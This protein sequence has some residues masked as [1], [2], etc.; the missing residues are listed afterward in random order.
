MVDLVVEALPDRAILIGHSMGGLIALLAAARRPRALAHL[1]L[2]E[3]AVFPSRWMAALAAR[4]YLAT[5][6]RGDRTRF[7]NSN[8]AT[9]RVHHL[10]RYPRAAIDLYLE[11]R[12]TADRATGEA[13]FGALPRLYPL[14]YRR[15]DV[16]TLLV[17]GGEI[18]WRGRALRRGLVRALAPRHL[19]CPG[20]AHWLVNEAD[21]AVAD[22]IA[23][24]VDS[25]S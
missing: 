16:P 6:V 4:R 3:P 19:S 14:P 18:G 25:T 15:V 17:S 7:V 24:F 10:E 2:L 21:D 20:A 23:E 8:G 12:R 1:V 9:P 5:V 11:G 22:A 13:L